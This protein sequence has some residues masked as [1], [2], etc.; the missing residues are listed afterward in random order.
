MVS[1]MANVIERRPRGVLD[2]KCNR[3]EATW[4]P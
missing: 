2:G 1:L 3:K 4:C